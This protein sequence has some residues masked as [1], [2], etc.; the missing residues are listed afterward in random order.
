MRV[1]IDARALLS[2]K[3]GIGTYTR[4]I[5]QGLA[6]IPGI[7]VGLFTPRP[8]EDADRSG[9]WKS[10]SDH[11]PFGMIWAQTTLDRRCEAWRADVLL[12]A[13]TIAPARAG[14]PVV[15]VV[16]DLTP[17][18]HPEWHSGR[19][20]VGFLPLW[21][22]TADRAALLV[23]VSRATAV[24]LL[25]RYPETGP[26]IR[27][28]P[29]GVD[30]DFTP[31]PAGADGDAVRRRYTRGNRYILYLGTLEPR[32]NV[33][34]LVAA[35]ER[36]WSRRRSRP[37]LL[38]AGGLGWKT[39]SLHRRIARSPY[40]D[41]IHLAGYAPH[42]LAGDLYRGAEVFVYPSLCEGFGLPVLEAMACGVPVVA[43]TAAALVEVGGDAALYADPRD[44]EAIAVR[45][46]RLLDD[47]ELRDRLRR[48]G[49]ERAA[50]FSWD[51]AAAQTAR[52]LAE[53]AEAS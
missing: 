53:A 32:K 17:V 25:A 28:V 29:N 30:A 4:G 34:S 31:A 7:E 49:P 21:E 1:A 48:A 20:L 33:E 47:A 2:Q 50:V 46:E 12:A 42:D 10:V 51:A 44:P 6:R 16:H 27:I 15:S 13:L 41:K 14:L 35:C 24:D 26:R 45:I 22:R 23:C 18:D 5:A 38:L 3:T 19:T 52:L 9:P 43:S 37:D 11:H 36:V 8:L 39:A 40:R